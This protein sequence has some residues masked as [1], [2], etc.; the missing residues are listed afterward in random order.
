MH[1]LKMDPRGIAAMRIMVCFISICEL[2]FLWGPEM[3]PN[4][5]LSEEILPRNEALLID[6]NVFSLYHSA[7]TATT[8]LMIAVV[9][10][11][12]LLKLML[13]VGSSTSTALLAWI[14]S[15]SIHCRNPAA[16]FGHAFQLDR[17]YIALAILPSNDAWSMK[18][19]TKFTTRAQNNIPTWGGRLFAF[20]IFFTMWTMHGVE[21]LL[22]YDYWWRRGDAL[23][24]SLLAQN[25]AFPH[26]KV[27]AELM[28]L[29]FPILK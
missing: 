14:F 10:L 21:K 7:G 24:L 25:V 18:S 2:L 8:K 12:I 13:G 9:H 1:I 5:I 29:N 28:I 4:G 19:F 17:A 15:V 20:V 22:E 3:L 26:T 6:G 27:F 11:C 23:L 16:T